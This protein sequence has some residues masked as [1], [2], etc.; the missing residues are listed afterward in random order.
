MSYSLTDAMASLE[1]T[2]EDALRAQECDYNDEHEAYHKAAIK[3]ALEAIHA[4]AALEAS[5]KE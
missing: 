5:N 1:N 3:A 2:Y 4:Q